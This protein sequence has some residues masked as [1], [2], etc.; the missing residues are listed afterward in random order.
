MYSKETRLHCASRAQPS[1]VPA[2]NSQQTGSHGRQNPR[3]ASAIRGAAASWVQSRAGGSQPG[4]RDF[5]PDLQ[6]LAEGGA[7]ASWETVP[8]IRVQETGDGRGNWELD[9]PWRSG[10]RKRGFAIELPSMPTLALAS[11]FPSVKGA[12]QMILKD[13]SALTSLCL[14]NPEYLD[15]RTAFWGLL[16][17]PFSGVSRFFPQGRDG[18]KAEAEEGWTGSLLSLTLHSW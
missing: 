7:Q 16:V 14:S 1:R 13:D 17:H 9:L 2:V 10:D 6:P 12:Q 8:Q 5:H 3:S 15:D 11:V 18:E 4:L